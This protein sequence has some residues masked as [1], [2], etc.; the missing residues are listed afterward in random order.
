M[1]YTKNITLDVYNDRGKNKAVFAKQGDTAR[2]L[3]VTLTADGVKIVPEGEVTA[4]FRVKKPDGHSVDYTVPIEE[5]GTITVQL[6]AQAVACPGR[7]VADVYLEKGG[8]VL[9][10]ANFDLMVQPAPV[11]DGYDSTDEYGVM[12]D[13]TVK[14]REATRE[15]GAATGRATEA[16]GEADTATEKATEATENANTAAGTANES[17]GTADA[18]AKRANTAAA[19]IE[20]V[21]VSAEPVEPGGDPT[22]EASD[23]DG[24][25]HINFGIPRG[26]DGKNF[27]ILGHYDSYDELNSAV[28]DPA[29]GDAY[30]VGTEA[31]YDVYI[32]DEKEGWVNTGPLNVDLPPHL[33]VGSDSELETVLPVDADTLGGHP[34]GYFAGKEATEKALQRKTGENILHNARWDKQV[35][36]VN[37]RGVSGT[38]EVQGYFIDRWKLTSGTVQITDSGLVL[39]GTMVQILENDPGGGVIASVLT[40][41][42][43][44]TASY[45]AANKTFTITATGQTLLAAK[46]EVGDEQTLARQSGAGWMLNDPAPDYG[47]ELLQCQRYYYRAYSVPGNVN[48]SGRCFDTKNAYVTFYL[49]CSMRVSPTVNILG[50]H[51]SL[52]TPGKSVGT[53]EVYKA[54]LASNQLL[55]RC[56]DPTSGLTARESAVLVCDGIEVSADL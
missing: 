28:Q 52:S 39:D 20:G 47:A 35:Y 13:A 16:A 45:T 41:M 10:N 17:A 37:Q 3:K 55:L 48:L 8:T 33:I 9:S 34:A 32:Y 22:A 50:T 29:I 15:A 6:S 53:P 40:S 30:Q 1:D 51:T 27:T 43:L 2:V 12:V 56:A 24:H 44:G 42:G 19:A 54:A 46:L 21:T 49:P 4:A 23:K 31:P 18:A 5:D 7:C 25:L 14:A 36:I 38:I 26:K 11:G